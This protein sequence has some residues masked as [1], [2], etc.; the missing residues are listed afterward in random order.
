MYFTIQAKN[1]MGCQIATFIIFAPKN[2]RF[3]NAS[4]AGWNVHLFVSRLSSSL[5]ECVQE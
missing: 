4:V 2:D 3:L 5:P 1:M